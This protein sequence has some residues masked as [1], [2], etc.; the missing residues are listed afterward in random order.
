MNASYKI[1]ISASQ[2]QTAIIKILSLARFVQYDIDDYNCTDWALD[3]FNATVSVQQNLDIPHFVIPGGM[4]ANGTSTPN[5]LYIKLQQMKQGGGSIA[6]GINIP[7]IGW[8]GAS[9]GPC[10]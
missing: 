6:T 8:A 9:K 3:V 7:L 2:I 10:N 1:N 5:G 4:A